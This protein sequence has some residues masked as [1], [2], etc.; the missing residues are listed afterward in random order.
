VAALS[1]SGTAALKGLTI[2]GVNPD[3]FGAFIAKADAI[4]RDIDAA[5]TAGFAPQIAA[6]GS[7]PAGDADIA[8]TIA[9]G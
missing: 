1:G 3:A 7:F 2:A 8:F 9:G 5:K 6:D 4:G